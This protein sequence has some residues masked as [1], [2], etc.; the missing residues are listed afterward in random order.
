MLQMLM[1]ILY[2]IQ[3]SLLNLFKELLIVLRSYLYGQ[4]WQKSA[5]PA[6]CRVKIFLPR[7]TIT[8]IPDKW[9]AISWLADF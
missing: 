5:F 9:Q 6:E 3:Y 4:E 7:E 8:Q 2:D 1:E